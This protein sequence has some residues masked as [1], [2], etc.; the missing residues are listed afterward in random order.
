MKLLI[1]DTETTGLLPKFHKKGGHGHIEYPYIV[2]LGWLLYDTEL[3]EITKRGD[4]I[5]R[6]PEGIEIPEE[7]TKVHGITNKIMIEKGIPIEEALTKFN[8]VYEE[9]EL[10]I[11][12]NLSFDKE[13][14]YGEYRRNNLE[15]IFDTIHRPEF[16][17]LKTNIEFC[18]IERE[19]RYGKY[20]KYPKLIELHSKL[21]SETNTRYKE[22]KNLHDAFNDILLTL[23]CYVYQH[24]NE[25]ILELGLEHLN[26]EF[27][28]I[29][30]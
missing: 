13:V 12:H 17:T 28:R 23:R 15:P 2:Q 24:H 10:A 6:L 26:K 1:F 18:A 29:F 27:E 20:F 25:D 8:N 3:H 22:P 7:S 11:A 30:E 4:D 16:C 5:I 19:N 21:F 9:C 14:L